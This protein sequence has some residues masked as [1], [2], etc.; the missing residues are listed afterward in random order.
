MDT[1]WE[2][3]TGIDFKRVSFAM[4][5]GTTDVTVHL[6][7]R[8]SAWLLCAG[9]QKLLLRRCEF[10]PTDPGMAPGLTWLRDDG[11]PMTPADWSHDATHVLGMLYDGED[12]L[13]LLLN[14]GG[15][16]R[17]FVLPERGPGAW[18]VVVDT[19]H[20]GERPT[21]AGLTLAPRSLVLLRHR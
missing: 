11:S 6:R 7:T 18:T 19:A 14:G 4:T 5:T 1:K 13:L 17:P 2:H 8:K 21:E 20:E 16:S 10:F 3:I 12:P 15:R 9:V